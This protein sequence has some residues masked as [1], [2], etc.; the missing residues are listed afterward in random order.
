MYVCMYDRCLFIMVQTSFEPHQK[1]DSISILRMNL[2]KEVSFHE[3]NPIKM[4]FHY[5]TQ[6]T[7]IYSLYM[8]IYIYTCICI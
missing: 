1:H 2:M 7:L 4:I 5:H 6:Y 8:Y 3:F